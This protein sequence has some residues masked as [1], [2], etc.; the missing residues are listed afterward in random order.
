[1]AEIS[2]AK[3]KLSDAMLGKGRE[4]HS[5]AKHSKGEAQ[6][7]FKKRKEKNYGTAGI[8]SETD[9]YRADFGD[10]SGQ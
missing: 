7:I 5:G 1:M 3:E 4:Q 2:E 6:K 9:L 8:E 10:G